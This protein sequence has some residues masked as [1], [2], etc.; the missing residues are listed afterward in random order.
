MVDKIWTGKKV[1]I[2]IKNSNRAYSGLVLDEDFISI[3]IRDI[4]NHLVKINLD[5]ISLLQEEFER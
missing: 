2:K 1:Y 3:T 5:E 4:M